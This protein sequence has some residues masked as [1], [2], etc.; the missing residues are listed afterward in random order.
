MQVEDVPQGLRE[1]KQWCLWR[2]ETR[3]GK[4]TKVPY[5]V[6]GQRAKANDSTTWASLGEALGALATGGFAGLGL[7][8]GEAVAGVDVDRARDPET[9]TL[10]DEAVEII[11]TLNVY[12][13]VSPSGTGVHALMLAEEIPGP[14]RRTG[15]VEMYGPGSPRFFTFTG[16]H[17]EGTPFD[18]GRRDEELAA[19][20]ARFV[21]RGEPGEERAPRGCEPVGVDDEALV[22][23]ACAATNGSAFAALW[24]GDTSGHGND[25]SAADLALCNRLAFWTGRDTARMDALFRRSGLMRRKWDEKRG[26]ETYGAMTVRVAASE[27]WEVYTPGG[28]GRLR[29]E[30][31]WPS[32]DEGAAVVG[33]E[34]APTRD[35]WRTE[36]GAA[37][38]FAADLAGKAVYCAPVK[39]WYL[40]DPEAGCWVKDDRGALVCAAMDWARRETLLAA[41]LP[42]GQERDEALKFAVKCEDEPKMRHVLTLGQALLGVIPGDFD[43]ELGALVCGNGVLDLETRALGPHSAAAMATRSTG[44]PYDPRAEAPRWRAWLETMLP[45][46]DVRAFVQRGAG[47]SICGRVTDRTLFCCVGPSGTGKSTF[48]GAIRAALG[49]YVGSVSSE[50][51]TISD[52]DD[53][54]AAVEF[55]SGRFLL[56]SEVAKGARWRTALLKQ[57]T[58]A[59]D[60]CQAR[61]LHCETYSFKPRGH[62]WLFTNHKP[63]ADAADTA[64]WQRLR[65]VNFNVAIPEEKQ[66]ED[67]GERLAEEAA[68]ILAWVVE[69]YARARK[70][71]LGHPAAVRAA[72]AEYRSAEDVVGAFLL[73]CTRDVPGQMV[74]KA[75]LYARYRTWAES[76][77]ERPLTQIGLTKALNERGK[78][79]ERTMEGRFWRALVLIVTGPEHMRP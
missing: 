66:D 60:W 61:P 12:A 55:D 35:T 32:E 8:F 54:R 57:F 56:S 7:M 70:H 34:C 50:A 15:N 39:H 67:L 48:C 28:N 19:V 58:G 36:Q 21:A 9:G 62:V 25:D 37:R 11:G 78:Q 43:R 27:C 72:G 18:V 26:A 63:K 38:R 68:G 16:Q 42:A 3:E 52:M 44:V 5:Q 14:E 51:L 1:L 64:L 17:I 71:G 30:V 69:G 6:G 45:D 40:Y 33:A 76:N 41:G 4:P 53:L 22:A 23:R 2:V 73:E 59:Q 47:L 46:P 29:E 20:H 79:E 65:P 77:G 31:P 49:S 24:A 75:D 74:K 10:S 13:E